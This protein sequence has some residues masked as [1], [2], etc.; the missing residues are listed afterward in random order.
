[1]WGYIPL[2]TS[3]DQ[4]AKMFDKIVGSGPY[5]DVAPHAQLRIGAAREYQKDYVEAVK[6]Y[7]TA[8]DRYH[9]QPVIAADALYREGISYYKQAATAEYDQ[10]TAGQAIAAFTDFTTL[11]PDDKRVPRAQRAIALL[12]ADQVRGNF[13]IAQ[14]YEK[15]RKWAGAVVYYNEVLQLDP[16]SRFAAQARQRIESLKPRLQAPTS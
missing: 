7:A 2:Y 14:F 6:A 12:K 10:S 16:N 11:F 4:T 8:A 1:L 9:N 15:S 5:S 3:M 13:E